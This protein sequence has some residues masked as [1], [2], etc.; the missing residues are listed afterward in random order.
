LLL[1]WA[2]STDL[3]VEGDQVLAELLEAVKLGDLLL[4]FAQGA[5]IGEGFRHR[6]AGHAASEAKL[7]IMS[8]VVVLGTV[9]GGRAAAPTYRGDGAE[10]KIVKPRNSC[11]S[12]DR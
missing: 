6:L 11:R 1:D 12:S 5:G 10:S 3:V 8:Q 2:E 7:R 4:R 9:A